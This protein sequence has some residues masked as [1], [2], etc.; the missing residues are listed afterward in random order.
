[1]WSN[2]DSNRLSQ[3]PSKAY[4]VSDP[5]PNNRMDVFSPSSASIGV[6]CLGELGQALG[7]VGEGGLLKLVDVLLVLDVLIDIADIV[8]GLL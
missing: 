1:M 6:H 7:Q 3:S 5:A 4:A 2:L 8:H